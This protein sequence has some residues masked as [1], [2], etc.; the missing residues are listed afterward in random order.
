MTFKAAQCPN[1]GGALQVPDDRISVKCMFCGVEIIVREAIRLAAGRVKEFT[2]IQ[3]VMSSILV[4]KAVPPTPKAVSIGMIGLGV[5][6]GVCALWAMNTKD[7]QCCSV[8]FLIAAAILVAGGW[9][10]EGKPARFKTEQSKWKGACPYC[11]SVISLPCDTLGADC[12]ACA[13]RIVIRDERFYSVD[14]P[15]SGLREGEF[16]SNRN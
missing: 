12:P 11:A 16:D 6:S 7:V 5:L 8:I 14:T 1:C 4:S 15:V 10:K 2:S 9:P 3:P 13:K